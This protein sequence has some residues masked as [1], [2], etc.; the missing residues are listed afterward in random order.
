[1]ST[2]VLTVSIKL[3]R[4]CIDN[5]KDQREYTCSKPVS[6]VPTC[7]VVPGS[8]LYTKVSVVC[9]TQ[10][11]SFLPDKPFTSDHKFLESH[12][13]HFTQDHQFQ[14]VEGHKVQFMRYHSVQFRR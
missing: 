2:H 10:Y 11:K 5:H 13:F 1:M 12:K 4:T 3:T 6:G 14:F 7:R 9:T 8:I